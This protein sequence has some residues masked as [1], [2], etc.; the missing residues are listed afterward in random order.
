MFQ[1]IL[2]KIAFHRQQ[3]NIESS[4]GGESFGSTNKLQKAWQRGSLEML[5][6]A[7]EVSAF[8]MLGLRQYC[9]KQ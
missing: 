5:G 4:L 9:N 6:V 2:R 8:R 3:S 1:A 7:L